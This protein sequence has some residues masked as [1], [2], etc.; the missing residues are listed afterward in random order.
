MNDRKV[1]RLIS[2]VILPLFIGFIA[3]NFLNS[4]FFQGTQP[5]NLSPVYVEITPE[6][7]FKMICKNIESKN[8]IKHWK[9]LDIIARLRGR[10]LS[11]KVGEYLF[12]RN[13]SPIR[14]YEILKAGLDFK[15]SFQVKPGMNIYEVADAVSRSKITTR[16][17][18]LNN[19]KDRKLLIQ[20]GIRAGSL[21]GYLGIG[22][23][24]FSKLGKTKNLIWKMFTN[25]E[26]YWTHSKLELAAIR[27]LSRHDV[28][29]I[30]SLIQEEVPNKNQ[31]KDFAALIFNKLKNLQNLNFESSLRYGLGKFSGPI[32]DQD[33]KKDNPYN[34]TINSGLPP[35]PI[36]APSKMAIEAVL[37]P[38][39]NSYTEYKKKPNGDIE[40]LESVD[41]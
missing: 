12:D 41:E 3:Y 25:N 6:Q 35:T 5:G 2:L 38:A 18:F 33:L 9:V 20:A 7:N 16:E 34:L 10:N 1:I 32:G 15:R 31:F 14:I 8:L 13:M 19:A 24:K 27:N 23:Y 40:F 29:T 36:C 26:K 4:Y 17:D 21:E 39:I 30:A 22:K 11:L 37:N 28:L